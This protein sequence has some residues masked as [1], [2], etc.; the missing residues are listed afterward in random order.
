[1]KAFR[2]HHNEEERRNW[3]HP[4]S[5]LKGIGLKAGDAFIDIGCG[6]GFFAIPASRIV[7]EKGRVIASDIDGASIERLRKRAVKEGIRNIELV[8]APAEEAIH[9]ERCADFVFYGIDLH[10]FENPA[11]VLSN[12]L[13]MIGPNGRLVD[14][15]WKKEQ[16]DIGPPIDIRFSIEKASS[17]IEAAGFKVESVKDSGRFHY[18]ITART[19]VL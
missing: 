2:F 1:M 15:D 13:Q 8:V 12:A 14:L 18:Q 7:G 6:D 9:C 11:K 10:D 19:R 3:Q 17:L 4:E 16:M 5:I